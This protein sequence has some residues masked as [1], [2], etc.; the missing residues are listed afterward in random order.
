[1][2]FTMQILNEKLSL[3]IVKEVLDGDSPDLHDLK[4]DSKISP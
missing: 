4:Q 2:F 1:M 3:R